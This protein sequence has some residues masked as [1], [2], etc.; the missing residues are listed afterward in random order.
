MKSNIDLLVQ[1]NKELD[2]ESEIYVFEA[3]KILKNAPM[4][5]SKATSLKQKGKENKEYVNKLEETLKI[6]E[7]KIKFYMQVVLTIKLIGFLMYLFYNTCFF[8]ESYYFK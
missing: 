4:L 1:V 5:L 6:L 2:N 3:E 7:E 8:Q